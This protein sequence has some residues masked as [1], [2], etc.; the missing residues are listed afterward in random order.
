MSSVSVSPI[1]Q[2]SVDELSAR[3][4]GKHIVLLIFSVYVYDV[5]LIKVT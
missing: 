2:I 1:S 5:F 4:Q 3:E